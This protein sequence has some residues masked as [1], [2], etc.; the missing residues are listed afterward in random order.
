MDSGKRVSVTFK[1]SRLAK[2]LESNI[3]EEMTK[4]KEKAG[5]AAGAAVAA[6]RRVISAVS[7]RQCQA[8]RRQ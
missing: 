3:R 6:Y 1:P 7:C 8:Y 5:A 2:V 4:K